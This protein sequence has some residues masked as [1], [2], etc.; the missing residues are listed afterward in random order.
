[1]QLKGSVLAARKTTEQFIKEAR[2]VHGNL[3]DYSKVEYKNAHTK[4]TIGCGVHGDFRQPPSDHLKGHGCN[5]CGYTTA[6]DKCAMSHA[7]FK[8][9]VAK[10]NPLL[11]LSEAVYKNNHTAVKVTCPVHGVYY[12]KPCVLLRGS[13]CPACGREKASSS[14]SIKLEE[15]IG[16]ATVKHSGKYDY[17][18]IKNFSRKGKVDIVCPVHSVFS[19]LPSVHL[20]GSG[21]PKCSREDSANKRRGTERPIH[22]VDD[23]LESFIQRATE[24]HGGL[25]SYDKATLRTVAD[26]V[27]ITCPTHGDFSQ[28][29]YK[30]LSG[31]GCFDCGR[32]KKICIFTPSQIKDN[33]EKLEATNSYVYI[34]RF[35]NLENTYKVGISVEVGNRIKRLMRESDQQMSLAG[36]FLMSKY[37][38][39]MSERHLHDKFRNSRKVFDKKFPGHTESF[40]L[41]EDDLEYAITYL[42][43]KEERHGN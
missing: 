3:Y 5:Y 37:E 39:I 25:Y 2:G 9:A 12:P 35:N 29:A 38:A 7:E 26:K 40:I 30:H 17:S 24:I 16:R 14:L 10:V 13:G 4:V 33:K 34:F 15:F 11:D 19:Q 41:S 32:Y 28:A 42:E 23:I 36:S 43:R 18:L 21:C 8:A 20:N 31:Q 6:A 22:K 27:V 1:M